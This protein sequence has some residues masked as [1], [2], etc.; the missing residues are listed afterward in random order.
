MLN[1]LFKYE[2]Q[3]LSEM[4]N[5]LYSNAGII[6]P[7]NEGHTLLNHIDKLINVYNIVNDKLKYTTPTHDDEKK[8]VVRM[9]NYK[10]Y[11]LVGMYYEIVVPFSEF[12]IDDIIKSNNHNLK[13]KIFNIDNYEHLPEEI[14][15]KI[16]SGHL[17]HMGDDKIENGVFIQDYNNNKN[18]MQINCYALDGDIEPIGFY[19]VF[20][21]E[22]NHY[23]EGYNRLKNETYIDF[24]KRLKKMEL[25][26]KSIEEDD[27]FFTQE[28]K[29][30]LDEIL[31]RL[32]S[33]GE[34]NSLIGD[35]FGELVARKVKDETEL[36]EI[37]KNYKL[38][39]KYEELK[40]NLNHIEKNIKAEDLYNFFFIANVYDFILGNK[41]MLM[42]PNKFK[43][44]FISHSEDLLKKMY[45]KGIK[46]IGDYL[47][48]VEKFEDKHITK[49]IS[50]E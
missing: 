8:L 47:K 32:W 16:S 38:F 41:N 35:L 15:N 29:F 3:C 18:K 20:L 13:L 30:C 34:K 36:G 24:V 37:R 14:W 49:H 19:S 27:R 39:F 43:K 21:H 28:D 7:L 50:I 17:I 22:F 9:N 33:G 10:P 45:K 46:F 6:K 5:E 2:R 23:V 31:Y 48:V 25:L 40:D 1:R 44:F 26:R 11:E 4:F 12:G 42:T